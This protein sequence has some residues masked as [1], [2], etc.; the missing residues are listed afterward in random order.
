M[1][2][3]AF[4]LDDG[5]VLLKGTGTLV[6]ADVARVNAELYRTPESIR[7]LRYQICDYTEVDDIRL[8]ASEVREVARQDAEAARLHPQM[9]MA[10]VGNADLVFGLLRMW[11]AYSSIHG[12]NSATFRSVAEAQVWIAQTLPPTT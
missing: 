10:V 4:P 11:E 12:L 8:S 3:E 6:F 2:L 9:P 5:G 1:P 7:A